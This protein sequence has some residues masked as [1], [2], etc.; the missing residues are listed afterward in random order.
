[1]SAE[2]LLRAARQ[3]EPLYP[4]AKK[5]GGKDLDRGME[6]VHEAVKHLHNIAAQTQ[7]RSA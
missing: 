2:K 4:H 1:L 5:A 7:E 6:L 3:L